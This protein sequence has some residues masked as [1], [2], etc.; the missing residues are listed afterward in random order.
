[1]RLITTNDG[2]ETYYNDDFKETY[3][4]T[5]G[6][7]EESIKKFVE[8]TNYKELAKKGYVKILD[9]C[10]GLGYNS[11]A[12]IDA[13]LQVNPD[14]MIEIIGIESDK[15]ILEKIQEVNPNFKSYNM[16]KK[17]SK[18]YNL[19][20]KNLRL[21]I[22]TGYAEY[23]VKL[24]YDSSKENHDSF[25]LVFHDPFSPKK[26]P[27]LWTEKFFSDLYKLMKEG[28]YLTTYSCASQVRKNLVSAGFKV[29]DGPCVGRRSPSTVAIK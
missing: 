15:K 2:S 22:L 7:I 5:S 23:T 9:I 16:I 3:H 27:V 29:L 24:I 4:S 14:C 17:L 12:V 25:D 1:M 13:I 20:T 18:I 11:A 26:C 28:A 8:P 6:A 10:F 19:Q 21:M